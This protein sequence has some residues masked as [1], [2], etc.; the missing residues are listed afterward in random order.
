MSDIQFERF[1]RTPFV[2]EAVQITEENLEEI[3]AI[4]GEVK[5]KDGVR[6]IALDRRVVPNVARAFV[7]WTFTRLDD[8]YRCYSPKV[9]S[10]QFISVGND[11]SVTFDISSDSEVPQPAA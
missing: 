2:V 6:Y 4:I 11:T 9:F 1:V 10:Q 8:N 7:G 3:A 5:E